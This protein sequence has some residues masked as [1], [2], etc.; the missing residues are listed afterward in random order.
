MYRVF[1]LLIR[2]SKAI[3]VG[4]GLVF[5]LSAPAWSK[6][7]GQ[8]GQEGMFREQ[9]YLEERDQNRHHRRI[10]LAQKG[11][12]KEYLSPKEKARLEK[13]IKKWKSLPPEKQN[14]LRHRMDQLKKLSPESRKLY[15]KRFDQLQKLSPQER[16]GIQKMLEKMDSLSTQEKE[17]IH[18]RFKTQ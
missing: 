6:S 16:R 11:Q 4:T 5:S 17:K 10:V 3:T 18:Q 9:E 7:K 13:K 12:N 15:K 2:W 14:V 8:N 1:E